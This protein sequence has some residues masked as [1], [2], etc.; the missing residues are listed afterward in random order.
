MKCKYLRVG[1]IVRD[2]YKKK[3]NLMILGTFEEEGHPMKKRAGN[4]DGVP[5]GIG[6]TLC[7]FRQ[8]H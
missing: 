3:A 5:T 6:N 4:Q 2:I 8:V 1:E 7:N